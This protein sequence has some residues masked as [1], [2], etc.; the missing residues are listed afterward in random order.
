MLSATTRM[1]TCRSRMHETAVR[2]TIEGRRSAVFITEKATKATGRSVRP[3]SR[4]ADQRCLRGR[5][6][7]NTTSRS[8][9]IHRRSNPVSALAARSESY[10]R[11]AATVCPVES[12]GV[13]LATHRE[14]PSNQNNDVL[15]EAA[16]NASFRRSINKNAHCGLRPGV[17]SSAFD[18]CAQ[19]RRNRTSGHPKGWSEA[20]EAKA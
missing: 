19:F 15:R 11:R 12:T 4:T 18:S 5:E 9:R 8:L 20:E 14:G 1:S 10:F 3:A 17:E 2:E 16:A 6:R 13:Q 7:M